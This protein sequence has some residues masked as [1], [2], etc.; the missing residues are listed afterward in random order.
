MVR[1]GR[2]RHVT[3]GRGVGVGTLLAAKTVT[4]LIAGGDAA[5]TVYRVVVS[6]YTVTGLTRYGWIFA[7]GVSTFAMLL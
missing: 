1:R 3:S 6:P 7:I 2:V 5:R 4:C